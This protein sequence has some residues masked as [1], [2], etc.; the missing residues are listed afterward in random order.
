MKNLPHQFQ[1]LLIIR[2]LNKSLLF[3]LNGYHKN[4]FPLLLGNLLVDLMIILL[5]LF[6]ISI[7][8][9]IQLLYS[10]EQNQKYLV[11]YIGW[12]ILKYL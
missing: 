9:S 1:F 5:E 2:S 3:N 6:K 4:S 10:K 7:D 12:N 8:L 11:L